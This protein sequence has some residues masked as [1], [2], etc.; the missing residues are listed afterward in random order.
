MK[1][2]PPYRLF[3]VFS[4]CRI[5]KLKKKTD[6]VLKAPIITH[7]HIQFSYRNERIFRIPCQRCRCVALYLVSQMENRDMCVSLFPFNMVQCWNT[8][9]SLEIVHIMN[10]SRWL[11]IALQTRVQKNVRSRNGAIDCV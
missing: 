6:R 7:Y 9:D 4:A 11:L 8:C 5:V 2:V 3:G 10:A 1:Y